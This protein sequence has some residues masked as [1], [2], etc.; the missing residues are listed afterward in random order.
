MGWMAR[1]ADEDPDRIAVALRERRALLEHG[2]Q[3]YVA[4][5]ERLD[6]EIAA[7]EAAQRLSVPA[8][9]VDF[10]ELLH[11]AEQDAA[12]RGQPRPTQRGCGGAGMS[13][14]AQ[15]AR[16]RPGPISRWRGIAVARVPSALRHFVCLPPS[17][18]FRAP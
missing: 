7:L 15:I 13:S 6:D 10:D 2:A 9:D 11:R 17:A 16:T 12:A 1:I 18:T 4:L 14:W 3:A 5:A 8:D